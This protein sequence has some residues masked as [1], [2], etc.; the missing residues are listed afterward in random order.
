MQTCAVVYTRAPACP[1][2]ESAIRTDP[3]APEKSV[4]DVQKKNTL[5]YTLLIVLYR[6]ITCNTPHSSNHDSP[7]AHHFSCCIHAEAVAY[8]P[9]LARPLD[10]D[11]HDG[12]GDGRC[13]GR[14]P[15]SEVVYK[16]WMAACL[17]PSFVFFASTCFFLLSFF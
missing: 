4:P 11:P 8:K 12:I 16:V 6:S 2:A 15:S 5:I 10:R 7:T 17:C 9:T 1:A 13:G 14:E 3:R